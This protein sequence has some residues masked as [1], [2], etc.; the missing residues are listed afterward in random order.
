MIGKGSV[1]VFII[2]YEIGKQIVL[3]EFMNLLCKSG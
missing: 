1:E 3:H 2:F